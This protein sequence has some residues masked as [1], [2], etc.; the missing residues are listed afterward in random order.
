MNATY[1]SVSSS[2]IT[3]EEATPTFNLASA[4]ACISDCASRARAR[5]LPFA[6]LICFVTTKTRG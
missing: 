2:G 6:T 5:G 3:F 1:N 4:L